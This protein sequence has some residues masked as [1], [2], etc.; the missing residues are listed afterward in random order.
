MS[1]LN[2]KNPKTSY[3]IMEE[4]SNLRVRVFDKNMS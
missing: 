2:I 3:E 1:P 4:Y